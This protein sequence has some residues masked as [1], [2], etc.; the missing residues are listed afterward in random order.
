VTSIPVGDVWKAIGFPAGVFLWLLGFWFMAVASISV[1]VG[2]RKM[3]FTLNCWAFIFPN[4]GLTIALIQI[5]SVLGSDGI[6]GVAS[7][8]T[9]I[10]VAAW[11]V[12]AG[13]CVRAVVQGKVLWPGMDEDEEDEEG[14]GED[15]VKERT[16]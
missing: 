14:H 12:V 5:G 13:F 4:V 7:A 3:H 10:L 2:A 9:V 1:V 6:K 16:E 11:L 15:E 8:M